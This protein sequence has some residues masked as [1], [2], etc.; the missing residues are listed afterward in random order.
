MRGARPR[1]RARRALYHRWRRGARRRGD[2]DALET[3]TQRDDR[4]D[5]FGVSQPCRELRDLALYRSFGP[6]R[7][8]GALAK[9][10]VD[11]L[12]QIVDVVAVHVVESLHGLFD[13]PRYRDVD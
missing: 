10:G 1:S 3:L 8:A 6:L 5:D 4:R 9:I 13:V 12:L 7:L 2:P 11:D